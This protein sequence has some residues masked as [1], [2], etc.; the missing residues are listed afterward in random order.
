M[1]IASQ[2]IGK[3]ET[4]QAMRTRMSA[5]SDVALLGMRLAAGSIMA[6]HGWT[7]FDGGIEN[8]KGFLD[9]LNLPFSGVLQYV[10]PTLE[11]VGGLMI[12]VGLLTRVPALLIAIEMIFTSLLVKLSKLDLGIL[13]PEGAGGAEVDFLYLASFVALFILGAGRIS[14]D[15][16]LGIERFDRIPDRD[17]A[18]IG[19]AA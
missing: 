7:K 10:V 15:A 18:S 4:M 13:G 5:A 12:L 1:N 16:V 19:E 2:W 14:L 8:F 6:L 9:F 11:F 17:R 3:E